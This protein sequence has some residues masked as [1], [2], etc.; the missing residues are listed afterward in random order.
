MTSKPSKRNAKVPPPDEPAPLMRL[1]RPDG[2]NILT[3]ERDGGVSFDPDADI[4]D[5]A[6]K[7]WMSV[8]GQQS[9]LADIRAKLVLFLCGPMAGMPD[10]NRASFKGYAA[11]LRSADYQVVD[12]T[13]VDGFSAANTYDDNLRITLAALMGCNAVACLPGWQQAPGA[14]REVQNAVLCGMAVAPVDYWLYETPS[15]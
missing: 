15:E 14:V 4:D 6:R 12:P 7:F 10:N 9:V 13:S 5:M 1:A 2:S 3:V 11:L 8:A